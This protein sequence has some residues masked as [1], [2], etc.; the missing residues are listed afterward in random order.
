MKNTKSIQIWNKQFDFQLDWVH[1][2]DSI[3]HLRTVLNYL[4]EKDVTSNYPRESLNNFANL[5]DRFT[6]VKRYEKQ[7]MTNPQPKID[8]RMMRIN[9]Y[10]ENNDWVI[11]EEEKISKD[12][13]EAKLDDQKTKTKSKSK[14]PW[15]SMSND[16]YEP[17]ENIRHFSDD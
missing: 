15:F 14:N 1:I 4:I 10:K 17:M 16:S 13:K 7:L 5:K 11:D 2:T 6:K 3:R 12:E 9:R 8:P